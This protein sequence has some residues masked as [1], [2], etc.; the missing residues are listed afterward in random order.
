MENF[1]ST[2]FEPTSVVHRQDKLNEKIWL[3]TLNRYGRIFNDLKILNKVT[4]NNSK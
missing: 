3:C 1:L 4:V 2:R